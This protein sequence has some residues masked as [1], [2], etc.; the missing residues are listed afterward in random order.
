MET[1]LSAIQYIKTLEN[2]L[3][4]RRTFREISARNYQLNSNSTSKRSDGDAELHGISQPNQ[5][6]VTYQDSSETDSIHYDCL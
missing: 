6:T 4:K 1:L 3:V 5:L 2:E